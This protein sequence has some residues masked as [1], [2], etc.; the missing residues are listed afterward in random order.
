MTNDPLRVPPPQSPFGGIRTP[1]TD[2]ALA[3]MSPPSSPGVYQPSISLQRVAT[4]EEPTVR[5][6]VSAKI[7]TVNGVDM[8][9]LPS[10]SGIVQPPI[11]LGL[12]KYEAGSKLQTRILESKI[13]SGLADKDGIKP[14]SPGGKVK[15]K[16]YYDDPSTGKHWQEHECSSVVFGGGSWHFNQ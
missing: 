8:V 6:T 3:S 5:A 1:I 2:V 13:E 14:T 10:I 12:G 9:L 4:P 11:M 16:V 7:I 15:L